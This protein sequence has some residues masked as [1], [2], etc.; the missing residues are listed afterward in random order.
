MSTLVLLFGIS[1]SAIGVVGAASPELLVRFARYWDS[2]A[3]LWAAG[4]IRVIMGMAVLFAAPDSR[5]P[6]MLRVFG[7]VILVAGVATFFVGQERS[8]AIMEWW[9]ARGGTF[10]RVWA[11]TAMVFG[12]FLIYAVA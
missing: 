3:G 7:Y 9:F 11:G 10:K 5:A 8:H 4:V 6:G 2:R 1:I 12:F